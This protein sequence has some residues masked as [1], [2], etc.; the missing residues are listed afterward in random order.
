MAAEEILRMVRTGDI[1]DKKQLRKKIILERNRLSEEEVR[2]LSSRISA[3]I[4]G[5]PEYHSAASV[6]CYMAFR[7]EVDLSEL[8][9]SAR[10][11]GKKVFLPRI[12]G[13][14]TDKKMEFYLYEEGDVLPRNEMGIKEPDPKKGSA[15]DLISAGE[16]I[17]MIMPGVVFDRERRR[18][19]YGGGF[20]DRYLA[21]CRD[22]N[23]VKV[24]T[25]A[26]AYDLQ[27]V[28]TS[29][30]EEETDIRPD[31]IVTESRVIG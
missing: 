21:K 9:V 4:I 13:D 12:L 16:Q 23:G 11:A 24:S 30:P 20:Y 31:H 28:E 26:A 25:V 19:G 22:W 10:A 18:L 5:M 14:G 7:N 27:V 6:F 1:Q 2:S 29:L 17:L 15:E 3:G 8:M